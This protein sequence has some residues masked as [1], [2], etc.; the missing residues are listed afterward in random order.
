[1]FGAIA[2]RLFGTANDRIIKGLK[3]HV[4]AINALEPEFA[5]LSDEQ[6]RAKTDEFKKRLADGADLDDLMEEAFATVRE[7]AKRTLG[8]RPF[9]VQLIGGMVLHQGKISEM[10]TG[11]GKTL[12]ATL[13]VYLN[14]LT[15]MGVHVVTVNDYLAR[16]D[17]EWMGQ[18]YRFLGL[19]V[20][21]IVHGQTDDQRRDAY[22][23]DVTYATNNELGFDYLRDN[24]KF[25]L[26]E[27]VHRPFNYAIVDEVDSIL[28]DEARTP[29]IISGPTEDNSEL[30]RLVDAIMPSLTAEDFEKDEKVRA[31]TLTEQGVEHVE[32]LLQQA[33]LLKGN[34]YDVANVSLVHH[35]NQALR[36]HK[37]FT[38]DVD[39]IVKNDKVV[40]ID[41][42]TGRMMEGRRFSEGLHQALEA[43]E[44]VTIQNENQTLASITFQN[45]FRIYPK[46]AGMTGTAMTEAGEFQE[47]Y[48]LEVVEIPTNVPVSRIDAD[49][50]VYRTAREK[51]EAIVTLIEE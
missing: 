43:K 50:E 47:I 11:E 45:L 31:V 16:R 38:R 5:A 36:A 48:G 22:A 26:A 42:F 8:L 40:I 4:D 9:D 14:A 37:L 27:M 6:L 25:S 20:G 51:Y 3:K 13:P 12:V 17:A 29:L 23:C 15:G 2:R 19:T 24:M 7:A 39:Y 32:E 44:R 41:E 21:I 35:V 18:V 30:Y 28:V 1:M 33:G 49:D 34:L 46:L 10:K